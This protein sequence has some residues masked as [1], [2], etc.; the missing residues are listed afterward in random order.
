MRR[1][2]AACCCDV[3]SPCDALNLLCFQSTIPPKYVRIDG[4]RSVNA[5]DNVI[6]QD[7]QGNR[8]DCVGTPWHTLTLTEVVHLE[9]PRIFVNDGIYLGYAYQLTGTAYLNSLAITYCPDCSVPFGGIPCPAPQEASRI[10]YRWRANITGQL[11][12]NYCNYDPG[13][14]TANARTYAVA[15]TSRAT[16]IRETTTRVCCDPPPNTNRFTDRGSVVDTYSFTFQ[17]GPNVN[18]CNWN[19]LCLAGNE[20]FRNAFEPQT[21]CSSFFFPSME[22]RYTGSIKAVFSTV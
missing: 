20:G 6:A 19:G 1:R 4:A 16:F 12:C 15:A 21:I 14:F 13:D 18:V 3:A 5:R 22:Y 11:R 9:G 7:S 2:A 8:C 10:S 17:A